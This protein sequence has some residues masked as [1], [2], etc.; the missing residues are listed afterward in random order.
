LRNVP[1]PHLTVKTENLTD[2]AARRWR[3]ARCWF[4]SAGRDPG[5]G[6]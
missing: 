3:S 5:H 1:A 6:V 4:T 2:R